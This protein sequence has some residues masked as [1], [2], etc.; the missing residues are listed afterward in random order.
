VR[1]IQG[2][3]LKVGMEKLDI[4]IKTWRRIGWFRV[5]LANQNAVLC[6]VIRFENHI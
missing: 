3:N 2:I 6:S 5:L 4:L 1:Q